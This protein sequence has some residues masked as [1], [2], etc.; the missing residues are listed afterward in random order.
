MQQVT[1]DRR[2]RREHSN[3]NGQRQKPTQE[4]RHFV[5]AALLN[6]ELAVHRALRDEG[7]PQ[8]TG[9][10]GHFDRLTEPET[11]ADPTEKYGSDAH[12]IRSA[13]SP[14]FRS[15]HEGS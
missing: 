4:N 13:H 12:L 3:Q 10:Q 8:V 6:T 7:L 2:N 15:A 5:H 1:S 11:E 14:V 9:L